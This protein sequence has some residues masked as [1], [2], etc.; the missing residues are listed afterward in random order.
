[1]EGSLYNG[2]GFYGTKDLSVVILYAPL[3]TLLH[4]KSRPNTQP[5]LHEALH[6]KSVLMQKSGAG[7]YRLP[8]YIKSSGQSF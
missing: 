7:A 3:P 2:A 1:M 4:K 5:S 6:Q 8:E